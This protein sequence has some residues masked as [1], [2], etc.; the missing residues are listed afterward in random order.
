[1]TRKPLFAGLVQDENQQIVDTTYIGEE[2]CYVVNDSGFHRHIPSEQVDRQILEQMLSQVKGHEDIISEQAAK[3]LGQEDIFSRAIIQNQ[4]KNIDQQIDALF[5]TGIPEESI[6]YL[7]MM[8][9][10]VTINFHGDVIDYQQPGG[11]SEE[12]DGDE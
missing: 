11:S 3:M 12:G 8:G 6:A 9:M 7:G 10:R 4:L 2:P 5:Q 1:M